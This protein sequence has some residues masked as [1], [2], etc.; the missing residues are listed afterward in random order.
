MLDE[1]IAMDTLLG[2]MAVEGRGLRAGTL[3]TQ[4]AEY[5]QHLDSCCESIETIW[6]GR[7]DHRW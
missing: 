3:H 2:R 6:R 4:D 7:M 5:V 1:A